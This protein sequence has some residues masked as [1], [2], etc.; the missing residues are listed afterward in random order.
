M[1]KKNSLILTFVSV[2]VLVV[3]VVGASFAYFASTS[4]IT[5]TMQL[6]SQSSTAAVFASSK[7]NDLSLSI[8]TDK[9]LKAQTNSTTEPVAAQGTA[10]LKVNLTADA[11]TTCTYS[12]G[13]VN[14]GDAYTEVPKTAPNHSYEFEVSGSSSRTGDPSMAVTS[15][16]T[17]KTGT[18]STPVTVISNAQIVVPAGQTS[19][20]ATTWTFTAKFYN[21][22]AVQALNKT[23]SGYFKVTSVVC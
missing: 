11:G 3:V 20:P 14:T 9:M 6:V 18:S 4:N 8:T 12:I 1:S 22:N 2:L 5:T 13:Y 23:Y 15:Y 16:T 7:G 10:K 17:L 21:L 19:A